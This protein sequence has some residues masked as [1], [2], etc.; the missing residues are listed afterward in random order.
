VSS[1]WNEPTLARELAGQRFG[2]RV[3]CFDSLESTNDKALELLEQGE[4][5]GALV[6]AEEQTRGRGRRERLWDSPSGL[7]IYA[8]LVL[9]PTLPPG[10][11]PLVS[12]AFAVGTAATL[13]GEGL[14]KVALK[15]PNDLLLGERKLAG[16][17]AE[18]RSDGV[19]RGLVVGLGLNV[20]QDESDFPVTLRATATSLRRSSGR[21]WDRVRILKGVLRRCEAEYDDLQENG[22][23]D[24]LLRYE[25]HGAFRRG[26]E[27]E[28]DSGSGVCRGRFAGL[29]AAGEIL[30]DTGGE[31]PVAFHFGEVRRVTRP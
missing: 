17:L 19:Q 7:G 8:S 21:P 1:V 4:P 11:L 24:L 13:R 2:R 27:L 28:V 3:L 10:L 25:E 22:P 20:N 18:A 16:I 5:E 23:E 31:D 26:S 9:R 15:W 14:E 6:L 12:L 29:G 30:L